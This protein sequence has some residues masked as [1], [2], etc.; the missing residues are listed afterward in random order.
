MAT[1]SQRLPVRWDKT[2]LCYCLLAVTYEIALF[3]ETCCLSCCCLL[4]CCYV[5]LASCCA[6]LCCAALF[7]EIDVL[8]YEK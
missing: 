8:C 1:R 7:V 6:L 2:L 5:L 3:V 4:C